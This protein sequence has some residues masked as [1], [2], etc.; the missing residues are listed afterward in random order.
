MA[1]DFNIKDSN[2]FPFHSVY[3]DLLTDIA[4]SIDLC[5]SKSTNQIPTR[6]SDNVNDS[7]TTIDLMFLRP[8]SLEFNNHTIH[9]EHW[10]SSDHTPLI[11]DIS[12]FKEHVLT[13]QHTIVKNSEKEDNFI[14]KLIISIK[15][16]DTK[17]LM[18]KDALE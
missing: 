6:Y 15:R 18:S 2:I 11:V 10:Y 9:P 14:N 1:G 16:I 17:N 4:D 12:I 3:S 7:N 5:L 8:N 13:K